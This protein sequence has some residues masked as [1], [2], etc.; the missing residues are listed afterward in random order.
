MFKR[1]LSLF[2]KAPQH[3]MARAQGKVNAHLRTFQKAR[4]GIGVAIGELT[5]AKDEAVRREEKLKSQLDDIGTQKSD[6]DKEI[7]ANLK[8]VSKFDEFLS[9]ED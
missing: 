8:M 5:A 2:L 1:L 7:T 6:I 4:D 9:K 3:R